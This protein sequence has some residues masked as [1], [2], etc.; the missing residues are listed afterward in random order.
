MKTFKK[1]I[2]KPRLKIYYDS[3]E[4]PRL[5]NSNVGFLT[6]V[7]NKRN[8]PDEKFYEIVS[9]TASLAHNT[10]HHI[11]LIKSEI[12]K[13]F[14]EKVLFVYPINTY[15]HS[16]ISF[17][18]GTKNGFDFS[19]NGFFIVTEESNKSIFGSSVDETEIKNCIENEL[20]MYSQ[21]CNGEIYAFKLFNKKGK[22]VDSMTG[23][24]SIDDIMAYLPDS[25]KNENLK[26]Y[27]I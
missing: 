6:I 11:E 2:K 10:N 15:E 5:D 24:Y 8:S 22:L 1:I 4:S 25:W 12:E 23:F 7:S 27:L 13:N 19:N 14:N 17:S 16:N 26:N 18:I 9:N 20:S 21:W 3:I